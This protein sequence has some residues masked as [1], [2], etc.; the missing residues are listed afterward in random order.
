VRINSPGGSVGDGL[1]IYNSLARRRADVT[2]FVDGYALSCASFIALAGNKVVI[3]ENAL[4][5]IH[6]PWGYAQGDA[7][8]MRR[9]AD[10]LDTHKRG[11][12]TI[13]MEKTGKSE[14]EL[15]RLLDDETWFTGA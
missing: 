11:M 12:L 1:A 7:R 10:M 9:M 13:Y 2:T 4:M 6:N 15:D 3:A 8:E 14:A 5:M